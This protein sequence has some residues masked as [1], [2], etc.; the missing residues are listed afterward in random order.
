MKIST[1]TFSWTG[2]FSMRE[3]LQK[4]AEAGFD[5]VDLSFHGV[6]K[7]TMLDSPDYLEQ[8][9]AFRDM[10]ASYGLE[11]SQAH[12]PFGHSWT[13]EEEIARVTRAI[14]VCG[15]AKIPNIVVHPC[16]AQERQYDENRKKYFDIN[17][18]YYNRLRPYA[19]KAGVNIA[20]E[21]MFTYDSRKNQIAPSIFSTAE[22]ML[23]MLE[24]LDGPFTVCLDLG[25]ANLNGPQTAEEMIRKLGREHLGCLHIHDN[26]G[27][28]DL[29]TLPFTQKMDFAPIFTALHDIQYSGNFTYEADGFFSSL[30]TSCYPAAARLMVD[31][32][33]DMIQKYQL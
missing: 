9:A 8:A 15:V 20:I 23:E 11:I 29:H 25:H 16:F 27:V 21:N 31:L 7:T 22:E 28:V 4:H 6:E 2:L 1:S 5:A 33:R 19:E 17:V 3:T 14:E 10:A 13:D 18:D 30:P 12:A 26:D 24:V 32:A